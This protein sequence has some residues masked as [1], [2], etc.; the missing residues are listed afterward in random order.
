MPDIDPAAL[1]RPSMTV[2][3]PTLSN[4]SININGLGLQKPI[5]ASSIPS[6][7]DLEPY[8]AAVKA[9]IP[10]DKWALYKETVANLAFGKPRYNLI[11]T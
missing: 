3:T 6:R 9:F 5:K 11:V 1:S 2:E 10:A 4:K 7:I 8:Y